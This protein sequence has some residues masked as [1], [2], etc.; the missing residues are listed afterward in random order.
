MRR[1][2]APLALAAL[3][4]AG[5]GCPGRQPP[6]PAPAPAPDLPWSVAAADLGRTSTTPDAGPEAAPGVLWSSLIAAAIVSEPVRL[7]TPQ[8]ERL[9]VGSGSEVQ[10]LDA[11]RGQLAWSRDVG[12][13]VNASPAIA[14]GRLFVLGLDGVVAVLDPAD[15]S[16]IKR[17]EL[18][19][20]LEASPVAAAGLLLFEETSRSADDPVS[21]MHALDPQTLQ[22]RWTLEYRLGAGAVPATD[23]ETLFIGVIDGVR[24]VALETGEQRWHHAIARQQSRYGP[25]VRAGKVLTTYGGM[26]QWT[27]DCLDARTGS[28]AW[29][30]LLGDRA[31][32]GLTVT[33]DEVLVPLMGGGIRRLALADG[34]AL[35]AYTTPAR[36]DTRPAVSPR[37]LY[38]A[39]GNTVVALD[40]QRGGVAWTVE[41]DGEVASVVV[42]GERLLVTRFDGHLTCLGG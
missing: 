38:F 1:L 5:A 22:D 3:A 34:R 6:A 20:V 10:A 41:L 31:G 7:A 9:L 13:P 2:V 26:A 16:L 39:S 24:A 18:D 12:S 27:L 32:A 37:R 33:E 14:G 35:G 30:Q 19:F 15:G 28:L 11:A 23:G 42:A 21:T 36:V 40:R 25:A 8:G 17:I 29:R 4:V